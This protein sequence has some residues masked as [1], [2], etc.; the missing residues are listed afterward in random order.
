[1]GGDSNACELAPCKNGGACKADGAGFTCACADGF[2][3]KLCDSETNECAPNPC[4]NGGTCVDGPARYS[5]DCAVGFSGTTCET[6]I[7]GCVDKPCLNGGTCKDGAIAPAY[8]CT[9][10][11]GYTG[12]N[13]QTD[14]NDCL[15]NPCNGGTCTDKVAGFSCTC[16]KGYTG[17]TC[18]TDVNECLPTNPCQNSG[19]CVNSPGSFSCTCG[20]R[21]TGASCEFQKFRGIGILQFDTDSRAEAVSADGTVLVGS[22]SNGQVQHAIRF[23]G[24]GPLQYLPT[25]TG[26]DGCWANGVSGD[27]G[28]VIG[29]CN[30]FE[31]AASMPGYRPF[32]YT[33]ATGVTLVPPTPLA[34]DTSI[35]ALAVSDDGNVLVGNTLPYLGV[36]WTA[37]TG[38][39]LL[40]RLSPNGENWATAANKD[41]SVIVGIDAPSGSMSWRWTPATGQLQLTLPGAAED[42]YNVY[43]VTPNGTTIVGNNY[44]AGVPSAVRWVNGTPTTLGAGSASAVSANGSVAVGSSNNVATVY[45]STGAHTLASLL[46]STSDLTGWTLSYASDVSDDGKVVV[47]TGTHNGATEGFVAHLP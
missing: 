7:S 30:T 26:S 25:P 18:A 14:V 19:T 41:G 32:K 21:F 27:G 29:T 8:T 20:A 3:G 11:A 43:D 39:V 23:I 37:A 28:L 35:Q 46:G 10:P 13:C 2:E 1:M 22:S 40:G 47:G 17:T 6:A 5:C 31:P 15:P 33:P 9:C 36:R 4:K 24:S 12:A 16:P 45:N 38:W 34:V 42:S 44:A